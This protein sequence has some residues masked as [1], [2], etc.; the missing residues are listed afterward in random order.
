MVH[1]TGKMFFFPVFR[2]FLRDFLL[3]PQNIDKGPFSKE[4]SFSN[5]QFQGDMLVF[6]GVGR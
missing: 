1:V 4:M 5:H 2:W 3:P 6:G